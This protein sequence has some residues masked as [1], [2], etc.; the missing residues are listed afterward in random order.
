MTMLA[1]RGMIMKA[2]STMTLAAKKI[3]I[4]FEGLFSLSAKMPAAGPA[5]RPIP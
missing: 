3:R 5:M 1:S 2:A 4:D